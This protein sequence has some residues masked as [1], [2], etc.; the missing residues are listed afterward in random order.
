[1]AKEGRI[2]DIEGFYSNRSKEQSILL[3]WESPKVLV[4]DFYNTTNREELES[5]LD[6]NSYL[7]KTLKLKV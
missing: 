4:L 3:T 7:I 1:M 5:T 2:I 6:T